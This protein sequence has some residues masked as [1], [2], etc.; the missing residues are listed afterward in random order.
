MRAK[1]PEIAIASNDEVAGKL[2]ND[3]NM[4]LLDVREIDEFTFNH[5]P[6]AINI[7]LGDLEGRASELDKEEEIYII[8]RTGNRSDFAARVLSTL[9]F[10]KVFNVIPGMIQWTGKTEGSEK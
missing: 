1:Q 10:K 3:A 4:T 2:A 6:G 5:I 9:D 8:C 7:P